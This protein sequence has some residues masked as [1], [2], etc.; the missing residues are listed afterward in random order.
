M[1]KADRISA[2]DDF[3]ELGGDSLSAALAAAELEEMR[4]DYKDIYTWKTPRAI[5]RILPEKETGD[6]D[7]LN[8][9]ALERDQYLTPYQT[10][11]YD[12]ILYSP[13]QTGLSNPISLS[14][15]KDKVDPVRLKEALEKVFSRYALFSTVFTHDE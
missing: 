5:A 14:F 9:A 10:Y 15:P 11:F 13:R 2:N 4:V 12:A 8:R 3:F 1:L 6:L 7:A